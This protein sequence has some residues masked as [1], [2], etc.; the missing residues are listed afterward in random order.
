[1]SKVYHIEN[2]IVNITL[3][4]PSDMKKMNWVNDWESVYPVRKQTTGNGP[5]RLADRI[6]RLTCPAR[7]KG[8]CPHSDNHRLRRWLCFF[9]GS[10]AFAE[11]TYEAWL[12]FEEIS[13]KCQP[14]SWF[15]D[16]WASRERRE[17]SGNYL[18]HFLAS[19]CRWSGSCNSA[20][21][22]NFSKNTNPN[23]AP[24]GVGLGF[25]RF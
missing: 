20:A 15:N 5:T 7:N 18:Q 1:M 12:L 11:Y 10:T 16:I 24:L 17:N 19:I 22:F 3:P 23:P 14:C 25:A 13:Q 9:H 8:I 21:S 4:M 2:E 6:T